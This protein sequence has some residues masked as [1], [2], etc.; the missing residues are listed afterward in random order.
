MSLLGAYAS[1][2]DQTWTGQ[3]TDSMCGANHSQM[4]ATKNKEL[5]TSSGVPER[6]CTLACIK[7]SGKYVFVVMGK[8]YKIANQNLAALQVHAGE[9]VR[10]TG[11]LQGGVMTV[12]KI[13]VPTPKQQ[14]ERSMNH[15]L[16][17]ILGQVSN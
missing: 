7:D 16:K 1:A 13:E 8:A 9:T 15:K 4:I 3:I 10:L 6:D 17:F 5:R 2:A 12:S 14:V 11:A